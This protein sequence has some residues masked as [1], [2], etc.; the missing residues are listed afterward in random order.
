MK[1][2]CDHRGLRTKNLLNCG[3]L[4][5]GQSAA[6]PHKRK[7]QRLEQLLVAS[8]EAKWETPKGEEIVSSY[9]QL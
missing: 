9:R 8:S 3:K 6:K 5:Q 7:V 1:R 4:P 2:Y